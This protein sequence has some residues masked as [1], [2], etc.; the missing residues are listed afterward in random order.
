M[1]PE[2]V[3]DRWITLL[4]A[5]SA[6][7]V[8]RSVKPVGLPPDTAAPLLDAARA[9]AGQIPALAPLLGLPMPPPPGANRRPPKPPPP[10][11]PTPPASPAPAAEAPPV[12]APPAEAPPAEAPPAE[13]PPDPAAEAP[14]VEPTEEAADTLSH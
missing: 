10:P 11:P 6:S 2:T 7:P 4:E 14:P 8:R 3:P 1:S 12:A 5:V 13:A 9:A